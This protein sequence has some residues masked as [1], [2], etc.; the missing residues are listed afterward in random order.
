LSDCAAI[1]SFEDIAAKNT[2]R[3]TAHHIWILSDKRSAMILLISRATVQQLRSLAMRSRQPRFTRIRFAST[4]ARCS[5]LHLCFAVDHFAC[6]SASA[7]QSSLPY[8]L[9][10]QLRLLDRF[11]LQRKSV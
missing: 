11:W 6:A 3:P 2:S 7:S 10:A 8:A 1:P 5:P 9:P 4:S